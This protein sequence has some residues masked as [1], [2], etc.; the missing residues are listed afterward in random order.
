MG[1]DVHIPR[2]KDEATSQLERVF[3]QLV[4]GVTRSFCA[5]SS[6]AIVRAEE[7]KKGAGAEVDGAVGN[8]I[9]VEQQRKRNSGVRTKNARVLHVAEAYGGNAGSFELKSFF[10]LAQLRDMLTAKHSTVVTQKRHHAR[11]TGPQRA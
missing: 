9:G 5:R 7:V 11:R 3:T 8:A 4:L 1:V 10:A 6:F 2:P